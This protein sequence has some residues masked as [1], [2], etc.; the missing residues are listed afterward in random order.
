M[1]REM[2][3]EAYPISLMYGIDKIKEL[4]E[5]LEEIDSKKM[6]DTTEVSK[7]ACKVYDCTLKK[8]FDVKAIDFT[9]GKVYYD[10]YENVKGYYNKNVELMRYTGVNDKRN[11][12]IF[13]GYA[14]REPYVGA[15]GIEG[16][17]VFESGRYKIKG[18]GEYVGL[19]CNLTN[20]CE[21]IATRG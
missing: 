20:M 11:R 14:C 4:N 18:T 17:V 9:T 7:M 15:K 8:V 6:E 10:A 3:F 21:I 16:V 1:N 13:E 19:D 2:E 12:P 5:V